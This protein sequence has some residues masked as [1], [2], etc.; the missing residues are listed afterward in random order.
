MSESTILL[1]RLTDALEN[2]S[3]PPLH[4][5]SSSSSQPGSFACRSSL[6]ITTLALSVDGGKP[7]RLPLSKASARKLTALATPAPFGKG[8]ETL[9]DKRVRDV[10]EIPRRRLA[11][12]A[13]DWNRTLKPALEEMRT[14]L[15]LPEGRLTAKVDKLLIYGPGQFFKPHRDT[16]RADDMIG[17]LVVALPTSHK[18]GSLIVTHEG[19]SRRFITRES[20]SPKLSLYAFYADCE[21][22]VRPVTEGYR[23]VLSHTLHF[24]A[25]APRTAF[26]DAANPHIEEALQA[27]FDKSR[28]K[29]NTWRSGSDRKLVYLLDH[30]YSQRSLN[31]NHLK[32]KDSQRA[33]S[34]LAAASRL[35]LQ[36]HLSLVNVTEIASAFPT[37]P[38]NH[39]Y[40]DWDDDDADDDRSPT[41]Y[42]IHEIIDCHAVLRHWRDS[43]GNKVKLP[44]LTAYEKE[45]CWNVGLDQHPP[46]FEEYEGYMGNYGDTLEREYRRAAI[47][48]WPA[49]ERYRILAG[50]NDGGA[51]VV[52]ELLRDADALDPHQLNAAVASLLTVWPA[53]HRHKEGKDVPDILAL[54]SLLPSKETALDLLHSLSISA[55]GAKTIPALMACGSVHGEDFCLSLFDRWLADDVTSGRGTARKNPH[56]NPGARRFFSERAD[57]YRLDWL[58]PL[59]HF[60]RSCNAADHFPSQKLPC[61][62][63]DRLL[64]LLHEEHA[65]QHASRSPMEQARNARREQRELQYMI[66][67][68]AELNSDAHWLRLFRTLDEMIEGYSSDVLVSTLQAALDHQ[69]DKAVSDV[70]RSLYLGTQK[71]IEHR[72]ENAKRL[73]GD[74]RMTT[75]TNCSCA[76]CATLTEFLKSPSQTVSLPL[77][78]NRRRHLHGVIDG[79]GLPISH[80]TRR[81]G[82][83]Y[84]LELRKQP[85]LFSDAKK[86]LES[87]R[88][89]AKRLSALR[90]SALP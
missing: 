84:V 21:H 10:G 2:P 79:L 73:P 8:R 17:T 56:S 44:E 20:T 23:V 47:I 41:D 5:K 39:Y 7:L 22:E 67:A 43:S 60:V 27:Y 12:Q 57:L 62:V 26:P 38:R 14:Q 69:H 82:S 42:D 19:E 83:P 6:P 61:A 48:L 53:N 50:T 70:L 55:V 33:Q 29:E 52:R 65:S 88:S 74:W 68:L 40:D 34:L 1:S 18:G 28:F 51:V 63:V 81:Q 85:S 87:E 58:K 54:A 4:K 3:V 46:T 76:D 15:G 89:L 77:A 24:K 59:S 16:E 30:A 31:W 13:R 90:V 71:L 64:H 86:T 9:H 72:I 11:W 49:S 75:E 78:K 36:A 45:L 35:D 66:H 37:N 32:G 25:S 80:R